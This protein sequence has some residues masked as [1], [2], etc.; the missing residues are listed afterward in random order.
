VRVVK[1]IERSPA[2]GLLP[3]QKG[4]LALE[5]ITG[6]KITSFQPFKGQMKAVAAALKKAT[7]LPAPDVVQSVSAGAWRCVPAGF[8]TWFV[9]GPEVLSSLP[10]AA[11]SD[12]SDGWAGLRLT[13]KAAPDVLARLVPLDLR[14]N[15]FPTDKSAK[16]MLNHM[17][18]I[19]DRRKDGFD[20]WVFRSMVKTAVHQ[21]EAAMTAVSAR[22]GSNGPM[23]R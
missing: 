3:I 21:I 13:G 20:L 1:L 10:G 12:Q 18:L 4:D 11:L 16:T 8:E 9:F 14:N 6:V 19:I 15:A 23:S 22:A 2:A 17:A 5:E 7:K